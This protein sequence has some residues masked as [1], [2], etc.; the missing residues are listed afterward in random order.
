M[1]AT[2]TRP[3]RASTLASYY[4]IAPS[5]E[6]RRRCRR[7][8]S[9]AALSCDLPLVETTNCH[10][11]AR[12]RSISLSRIR[13]AL[14]ADTC[15]SSDS[16]KTLCARAYSLGRNVATPKSPPRPDEFHRMWHCQQSYI[17]ST[18]GARTHGRTHIAARELHDLP[19]ACME[20]LFTPCN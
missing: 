4:S 8:P 20:P 11:T 16:R 15:R 19:D 2:C 12:G 10:L 17:V 13:F 6:A 3:P 14:H 9:A 18:D 1:R 5:L 7:R